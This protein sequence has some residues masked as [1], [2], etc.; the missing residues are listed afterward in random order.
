MSSCSSA[1]RADERR[2]VEQAELAR[3]LLDLVQRVLRVL[4]AAGEEPL[5]AEQRLGDRP[6]LVELADQVVARHAHVV[7]EHL[8]ELLLARRCCGSAAR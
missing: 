6:A 4:G 1:K 8:A 7:E 3:E 2:V 5:E